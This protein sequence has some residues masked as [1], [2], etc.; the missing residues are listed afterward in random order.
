MTQQAVFAGGCFWCTEAA[1]QQLEGVSDVESGYAS[2]KQ[3]EGAPTSGPRTATPVHAEV[4]PRH[5]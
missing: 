3:G 2:G 5:V 4:D 1:F